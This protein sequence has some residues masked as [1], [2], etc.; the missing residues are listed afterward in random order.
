MPPIVPTPPDDPS[1]DSSTEIGPPAERSADTIGP[2][3]ILSLLGEGGMGAVY[4]AEQQMPHRR[5][6]VK[7]I[8]AGMD[9]RQVLARFDVEREALAMMEHPNIAA[10]YEAG[11]TS[12]GRPYFAM[13]YVAG[14]PI[15]DYCDRHQLTTRNRLS[16]FLPV[17][18]AIQ[19]A[20]QKGVI[21][22]DIKPSNILVTLVDGKPQPKV[23]DFGVAKATNQRLTEKTVF[24]ELGL[25]IGTPGYMSPEQAEMSGLDVD[26]T[27]DI[28]ALGVLLYELLA[29]V[30]PF[31]LKRLRSVGYDEI[32]RIIREEEPA[33]P[34]TR[35][36]SLGEA[37]TDVA[38]KHNTDVPSL[39]RQLQGDLDWITLKAMEKDRTRR[40]ASASEFAA[41]LQRHLAD[42]PVLARPAGV[43]YRAR[44]FV[45]RHRAAV[46]SA[47][48]AML[49]LA[50]FGVAM[51]MQSRRIAEERDAA[52]RERDRAEAVSAFMRSLFEASDPDRSKGEQV[53]ARQLLDRGRERL[54][55]ELVDQPQTRAAL[56]HT[57]GRVYRI[58]GLAEAAESALLEA[59][60]IRES[61]TG[62]DR[63]SYAD[64]L[65]ELSRLGPR[66]GGYRGVPMMDEVLR[67]RREVFGPD[68]ASVA[69]AL[70]TMAT[71]HERAGKYD[72]S[73][74]YYRDA[75]AM[76]GRVNSLSD[77]GLMK[78]NLAGLLIRQSRH[79]E[80]VELLQDAVAVLTRILGPE[81]SW[82]QGG[83][84][85]LAVSLARTGR[86]AEAEP[87][88]REIVRVRQKVWGAGTFQVAVALHNLGNTLHT[89]GKLD[90]AEQSLREAAAIH[91]KVRQGPHDQLGWT[92]SDLAWLLTDRAKYEEAAAIYKESIEVFTAAKVP[93]DAQAWSIAGLGG[94]YYSMG[95]FA[96]AER[97]ARE[98]V[99]IRQTVKV[100]GGPGYAISKE[101]LARVL[102]ESG[103]SSEGEQHARDA[104]MARQKATPREPRDVAIAESVLGRC[105]AAAKRF[106]E[107]EQLL[108]GAHAQLIDERR[109]G[110]DRQYTAR[111][112]AD[113]Y[114]A[115]PKPELAATWRARK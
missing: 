104:L 78:V 31:D 33:K 30:L 42:E 101:L 9:T 23:I 110:R 100:E 88:Q 59:L 99:Q 66:N 107:A 4:L 81:H 38:R 10:V 26:T 37:A 111:A 102:C 39:T 53:S 60:K 92:L 12:D 103:P 11:A 77:Q 82:V 28:Y 27:T 85:N 58:L 21:H 8:K 54:D 87:V 6:A 22:R 75:I 18:A 25:L 13:E 17:C 80:A 2:Y 79:P 32:R 95:R 15:T 74:R 16:L 108:L 41:D 61:A 29:G 113:L 20:H 98:A 63:A 76:A 47:A 83:L 93:G 52:A 105:L 19:H 55:R 48:A 46:G 43:A 62:N 45:R 36:S 109:P 94:M 73:E 97:L 70:A 34:S 65:Y 91:R 44:K 64:S 1:A 67:I 71:D 90:E 49:L 3:R 112:L 7:V 84:S 14:V 72:E 40:Y 96:D 68:H 24:T 106:D 114:T 89:L 86:E 35:L 56:L 5:V 57:I 50:T 115:W 51:A 69:Q